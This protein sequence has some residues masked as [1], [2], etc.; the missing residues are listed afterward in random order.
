MNGHAAMNRIY[1]LVWSDRFMTWI[2]AAECTRGRGKRSSVVGAGLMAALLAAGVGVGAGARAAPAS[3]QLPTGGKVV[4]GQAQLQQSGRTLDINQASQRAVIDWASFNVGSA[5]Q[6]NFKQ[7]SA[8]SA[9]LNRVLD[10]QP[11]EILGRITANGQVFLVNPG[12]VYFGRTASV[13]VGGLVATTHDMANEDFMAGR[14]QFKRGNASG[15]VVN[16]GELRAALGG[17]IALLAPE[18]RNSGLIVAQLGTVALASGESVTLQFDGNNSLAG[19]VVEPSKIKAL[20]ENRGAVLAPGGIIILSAQALDRLQGGVVRNSGTLEATGMA[21]KGGKIVLEASDRIDNSGSISAHAG[22]DGSPAGQVTLSAPQVANLGSIAAAATAAAGGHIELAV[23]QFTQAVSGLLDAS[24]AEQG[25]EIVIQASGDVAIQGRVQAASSQGQG[26]HITVAAQSQLRLQDATVDASGASAGG[27]VRLQAEAAPQP[28]PL[29][30]TPVDPTQPVP[31]TSLLGNT[32]VSAG[33]RRGRGGEVTLT[34]EHVGLFDTSV[35]DVS[36]ASG[37]GRARVGGGFQGSDA[38]VANAQASY[39]APGARIAADATAQGDGGEV[40]VWADGLTRFEGG[41]SARGAADGGDGGQAEVSGKGQLDFRGSA[42]LRAPAG[43]AGTL[44][45]DP[46]NLTIS[47]GADTAVSGATPFDATGTGSVLSVNTL[48]NALGSGNVTVSTGAGGGEAGTITVSN[49][50][51]WFSDFS[52]TMNAASTISVNANLIAAGNGNINLNS[53]SGGLVNA[54]SI[55]TA[56]GDLTVNVATTVSGAGF[57]NVLGAASFTAGDTISLA[58]VGNRF[59]GAVS[60]LSATGGASQALLVNSQATALKGATAGS[61]GVSI[62]STG[63]ITTA[64]SPSGINTTGPLALST[65]AGSNG[66]ITYTGTVAAG[67]NLSVAADG[68][69][70]IALADINGAATLTSVVAGGAV[71]LGDV[72]TG[73]LTLDAASGNVISGTPGAGGQASGIV[74][75]TGSSITLNDPIRTKGGNLVFNATGGDFTAITGADITTTADANTATTSGSVTVTASG[76]VTLKNITTSGA[77]NNIGVGSNGAAVIVSSTSGT[78]N[79]GAITTSGG[80]ATTGAQ[81]NRNGGN[82]GS[83]V[84]GAGAVVD[85]TTQARGGSINLNG[86]L[87]AI[88]GSP[89][90]A[91]TQGLGGYIEVQSPAVLTANR[92]VSSGATSGNI[93]F[94]SNIDSDVTPRSLTVTGGIGDVLMDG[95]VGGSAPLSSL[96]VTGYRIDLEK[97]ITTNAAGGVVATA[98]S[99][100]H[101]GDDDKTNGLG[102]LTINTNAGNGVVTLNSVNTYL[103]DAVTITRGSGAVTFSQWLYSKSGERNNLTFNGA[104]G[105][106]ISVGRWAGGTAMSATTALGDVLVSTGTDLTFSEYVSAKSLVALNSTGRIYLG[107]DTYASYFDGASGVQLKTTGTANAIASDENIHLGSNITLSHASAPLNVAA[108]NGAIDTYHFADFTTAGGDLTLAAGTV[109]TSGTRTLTLGGDT[110]LSTSGGLISLTGVGVSQTTSDITLNAGSGKIRIDGGGGAVDVRSRLITTNADTGGT[111]A[112]LITNVGSANSATVRSVTAQTGSFQSGLIAS[113][114]TLAATQSASGAGNLNLMAPTLRFTAAKQVRITSAGDDSGRSFTVTGTDNSGNPLSENIAGGNAA[115]VTTTASF[116]T[117]TSIAINGASAGTVSAGLVSNDAIAGSLNQ[118]AGGGGWAATDKIDIKTLS[119]A[120]AGAISITASA[121][122]IDELGNFSVGS[123]LDVR[124]SGRSTGMALTGDVSATTVTIK[125]GVGPLALGTRSITSTSGS[126]YLQGLGLTQSAGSTVNSATTISIYGSDYSSGTL[127]SMTLAGNLVAANTGASAI[128][129]DDTNALQLGNVTAGTL[130]TRGGLVLGTNANMFNNAG[131]YLGRTG[132]IRGALTQAAGTTLKIGTLQ[133]YQTGGNYTLAN[134]GNEIVTLGRIDRGGALTIVDTDAEANGLNS[135]SNI[136]G[137]TTGNLISITTAGLLNMS[138]GTVLGQG[139][140]LNSGAAGITSSADIQGHSGVAANVVLDAGSGNVTLNNRLYNNGAG[141]DIV[142]QNANNVQLNQIELYGG[143]LVLGT[144]GTPLTGNVTATHRMFSGSDVISLTGVV[145]GSANFYTFNQIYRVGD[146]TSGGLFSLVNQD[147]LL[148]LQGAI[149]AA[150]GNVTV[151]NTNNSTTIAATG[152]V[153]ATAGNVTIAAR[154]HLTVT[155]GGTVTANTATKNVNLQGATGNWG[156]TTSIQGAISAGS[157]GIVVS[158]PY[159]YVTTGASGTLTTTGTATI[160]SAPNYA[161]GG[162]NYT[163]VINAAVAADAGITIN[164]AGTFASN[165]AGTLTSSAG[166]IAIKTFWDGSN[167]RAL[168]LGGNVSASA[169]GV[170]LTSA[171][172]ITQSAGVITT[173][174]TVSGPNQ[175]GGASLT[176]STPSARGAVSLALANQIGGLGPFYVYDTGAGAITVTDTTGGLLLAGAIE[177]SHGAV[178]LSTIGGALN[179]GT[180]N[181][182]AGGQAT[183]GAAI[184][185]TGRG[186]IQSQGSINSTGGTAGVPRTGANGGGTITLTGHDGTA[187]GAISLAGTLETAN[188][189]TSA[190]KIRGTSDLILPNV[191]AVNGSLVLGDDTATVG[192]ITGNVTQAVLTDLDV[193]TLNLGTATNAIG[194]SVVVANSGNTIT[195]LGLLNVGNVGGTQYDLDVYD[196]TSGLNLTAAVTSAGGARIRTAKGAGVVGGLGIGTQ[197]VSARGDVF[198]GGEGVTQGATSTINADAAAGG[199]V[200]GAIRVDGGGGTNAIDL[201]GTVITDNAGSNAIQIVNAKD[202]TLN[203]ISAVAGTVALGIPADTD[204]PTPSAAL[205]LSGAVTQTTPGTS[206][207][208]AQTLAI[209]AG[210]VTLSKTAIDNLGT[211][212]TTGAL[213]LTDVAGAGTAG[214]KLTGNATLGAASSIETTN[215]PL[216]LDTYTV[217]ATGFDMVLKGVGVSQTTGSA[218]KSTTAEIFGSTGSVD[219]FSPLNN[220]T[221]QV[222]VTATGAAVNLQD[223]NQLSMNT[224]TGKLATTT[225]FK[226]WAGTQVVMTPE[227]ITT[228]TGAIE[229]KSLGGNLAT[230]GKLTT[231]SGHVTLGATGTVTLS[232]A[233][234]S[235]SGNIAVEGAVIAS[236]SGAG[237]YIKTLGAG[238]ID[239]TATTGNFTQGLDVPYQSGSGDITINAPAGNANLANVTSASGVLEVN[240]GG[241]V[242]QQINTAVTVGAI[243]V[244]TQKA[245]GG[246]IDLSASGND[247]GAVRLRSLSADGSAAAGGAITYLD[248]TGFGVREILTTGNVSLTG[249]A[250]ITTDAA[251]FPGTIQAAALT[252]KTLNDAGAN[253]T[254][255]AAANDIATLTAQVLRADGVTIAGNTTNDTTTGAAGTV[256]VTDANGFVVAGVS[257]GASTVLTGGA[258][259]EVTQTGA[260]VSA[261]LGLDGNAAFTLNNASLGVPL[262]QFATFASS[263]TGAVNVSTQL[264]LTIG[265]VNPTGVTTGGAAL[266][267][268]AP[269]ISITEAIDTRSANPATAGGAVTLSTTGTTTAGNLATS[270]NGSIITSGAAAA[271][272][273]GL[274]GGAAGNVTLTAAG[275]SLTV[276]AAI[277]ALGGAGDGAG[278]AGTGGTVKLL[279]AA[280]AVSQGAGVAG[281]AAGKLEV[282]AQGASS[283][284]STSN[285]AAQLAA[286]ITGTGQDFGYRSGSSFAVGGGD[287]AIPGITTQGGKIDLDAGAVAISLTEPVSTRGGVFSAAGVAGFDSSGVLL[288]TA[289]DITYA[290]GVYKDGGTVTITSAAGAVSTGTV[291]TDGSAGAGAANAGAVTLTATAG[292]LTVGQTNA[293]GVGTGT[294][295]NVGLS[296]GTA[297]RIAGGI[298]TSGGGGAAAGGAIS[299]TGPAIVQGGDRS[300]STGSGAGNI[301]FSGT[302]NSDGTARDLTLTAGTGNITLGG[303]VGGSSPLDVINIVSATDVG[304]AAVTATTLTQQAGS[305]TTT[306]AGAVALSGNLGFIGNQLTVNAAVTAAGT[307]TISNSG[308]FTTAAAGDIA[309]A[310]GFTQNGT[311][312]SQLAGDISSTNTGIAFATPVTLKGAVSMNTDT[313]AGNIV[314]AS[315]VDSDGTPRDLT[316]SAGTGAVTLADAAGGNSALGALVANAA[317]TTTFTGSVNAAS[318]T[319]DAA[320]TTAINGGAVTTSGSQTYNDA[321]T[322][323]DNTVLTGSSVTTNGTITGAAHSLQVAGNAV[324]GDAAADT[325]TGLTT[326]EVTGTTRINTD[327]V[328]SADAQ[329]YTGA[330]TLGTSSTLTATNDPIVFAST[331]DS[332]ASQA[333]ALT[334]GAGSG[335][336]SFGGAVGGAVNGA[337]GALAVNSSGTTTFSGAVTAASVTTNVGGTVAL[338]GGSVTTSGAQSYG[339]N[340][341]LG[342]DTALSGSSVAFAGTLEGAGT[343]TESLAI[344]GDASFASTVGAAQALQSLSVSGTTSLGGNVSTSEAGGGSGNQSYGG[345]VTL[346]APAALA[347]GSGAVAVNG[348]LVG[349]NNALAISAGSVALGD[350]SGADTVGGLASLAI[351]GPTTIK[352]GSV[353]TSGAQSYDG[354]VRIGHNDVPSTGSTLAATMVSFKGAVDSVATEANTLAITGNAAFGDGTGSD[355]VGQSNAGGSGKLGSLAVSGSTALAANANAV[356]TTGGQSYGGALTLADAS[357][358]AYTLASSGNGAIAFGSSVDG[359]SAGGNASLAVNTGG[360]SSFGGTVGNTHSLAALATDAGGSTAL[361]GG[362]VTTSGTQAYGDAVVLGADTTLAGVG[363]TLASTV[364]SDGTPRSLLVNDSGTTTLGG[365]VGGDGSV[366]GERL[367]SLT[368]DAAGSLALDASSVR[369]SGAQQYGENATL[370]ADTT[371]TGA[372]VAFSGT[373]GGAQALTVNASGATTFG[374]LVGAGTALASLSTDG[375]GSTAINGGGVATSGAQSYGD[376]VT[377]GADTTLMGASVAFAKKVDGAHALTVN[378]SGAT[379]FGGAVGSV[380]AL[381]TLATDGAGS[382]ALNGGGVATSGAQSYGDD[383]TLGAGTTLGGTDIAFA[384]KID[385]AQ[386]LAVNASGATRFGGAIGSGTALTS[387]ATDAA[388]STAIDGGSVATNGAQS[389]GDAVTLGADTTLSAGSVSTLGTVD[390]A[391][392]N[393]AIVGNAVLGDAAADRISGLGTLSVSGTTLITADTVSGSGTQTYTGALTLG[394]NTSL[395]STA[396]ALVFGSTV[397]SAGATPRSLYLASAAVGGQSFTAAVGGTNALDVLRIESAG[398]V[399]QGGSAPIRAAKLAIK[400]AGNATLEHA[401][402]DVDVLAALLSGNASLSFVDADGLTIGTI[403]SA[404]LQIVGI[405][406]GAGTSSVTLR[407]GGL[408]SQE[409]AAPIALDGNLTLDTT[410]YDADDVSIKNTAAGG[411]SLDNSLIAGD[412]SLVSSGNVSQ[413]A[414]VNAGPSDAWLQVGGNFNT[415]GGGSFAPGNS[416]ENLF[417]GGGGAAAPNQIRLFGVITLSMAGTDLHA[418]A[419]NGT[420]TTTAD[421]AAAQFGGGVSVISDAGGKNISVVGNGAAV[422]LGENNSVGGHLKI[423]TAGTYSNLG[424][425]VATGIVQSGALSLGAAS[426]LVQQSTANAGSVIAGTGTLALSDAANSFTGAVSLTALGMDATLASATDV[427]FGAANVGSLSVSAA[428]KDLSQATGTTLRTPTLAIAA[429]RHVALTNAN[430]VGTLSASSSGSF[431]FRNDQNLTIGAGGLTT[432]NQAITLGVKGDLA[433]NAT[434][435]SGSAATTVIAHDGTALFLGTAAGGGLQLDNTELA[436]IHAGST[437]LQSTTG[438]GSQVT[439]TAASFAATGGAVQLTAD[440][441]SLGGSTTGNGNT[442]RISGPV[443][444][445]ADTL[446]TAP[447]TTFDHAVQGTTAGAESLA[448]VGDAVFAANVGDTVALKSLTVSGASQLAGPVGTSDAGGGSGNQSYGGAV[449]LTAPT[450][451]AAT[452]GTV[453]LSGGLV[454]GG[455]TLA[456][457][458]GNVALGDGIGAD[459]IA[460]LASLDITGATTVKASSVASSGAQTYDGDV[461]IGRNDVPATGTALTASTVRFKGAVD[462]VATESNSLAII[463]NAAFGDGVGNDDVG[464]AQALA[465]LGV[466]GSTGLAASTGRISSTGAQTYAGSLTLADGASVTLAASSIDTAAIA[467]TAGGTTSGIAFDASGAVTVAGSVGTDIGTVTVTQSDGASFQGA[468]SAAS[469]A[470]ADSHAGKTVAFQGDLTLTSGLSAAAGTAAYNVAITGASN[471]IAGATTLAHSGN[472]SLGD[473]AGDATTFAGGLSHV[474]GPSAITGTVNATAGNLGLGA[475]TLA[476]TLNATAGGVSTGSLAANGNADAINGGTVSIGDITLADGNSLALAGSSIDTGAIS[477]TAAGTASHVAF[478]ATGAVTVGGAIATDIASVTVTR[479]AGAQFVGAVSATTVDIADSTGTVQFDAALTATTLATAN[480]GYGLALLGGASIANAT[481]LANTGTLTLGDGAGD[482]TT[483]AGGLT[484]TAAGVLQLAGTV[485][486]TNAAIV[487]GSARP[488]TLTA[489][490]TLASGSADLSLDGNVNGA[491]ALTLNSSGITRLGGAFGGSTALTA[492]A[493]DAAGSTAITGGALTLSGALNLG[494]AASI[495]APTTVTAGTI[496]TGSTLA[497]GAH[498]LALRTDA[499]ALGGAVSGSGALSIAPKTAAT[500]I[501]IA[502]GNGALNLDAGEWAQ[503]Q[504]GFVQVTVGAANAGAIEVGA[505]AATVALPDSTL[506]RSG[507]G[508]SAPAGIAIDGGYLRVDAATASSLGGVVSGTGQLETVGSGALALQA[509]APNT[510]TGNTLIGSGATLRAVSDGALASTAAVRNSGL[511]DVS[512]SNGATTATVTGSGSVDLG[513]QRLTLTAADGSITG[514]ISGSGGALTLQGGALTLAGSNS[515][516]GS[517][518]IEGGS[519]TASHSQALGTAAG[520]TA[521]SAGAAL[522]LDGSGGALALAEPLS[523]AGTGPAG[524]GALRNLAGN[525]SVSGA[526][527]L[528]AGN[529]TIAATAGNLALGGAIDGGADL[530]IQSAGTVS[531]GA[532]VGGTT[533][534]ASLSTDASGSTALNGGSV[535]TTGTQS[536]GDAL[537]LGA[538]TTL[539]GSTVTNAAALA[540]AGHALTVTGDAVVGGAISGVSNL[541]VSGSTAVGADVGTTGTQ[542]YTGAV[543]LTQNATLASSGAG[544]AANI[545]FAA[546]VDGAKTL[547][548]NSAGTVSFGAAV[549]GTTALTSLATDAAGSTAVNGGSVRTT[550]TQSYGDALT[551]GAD[552]TL[553][554]STVTNAAVLTGA[555]HALTVTGNAVVGGAI[556]GVSNLAVSGSTAMGADIGTTGTQAYSGAVSLTQNATLASSGAGAAG[557]IAFA[558]TVDGAK[559]L[560]LNSAG[561]VSFGAA[562]GGT[563]ALTSLATDATGSTAVNGGSVR[564]TGTQ[565]YGDVIA[566]GADTTLQGSTVTNA[567][568]LTGAGHA[569]TVTGDAVVGGAISGVSNLAVSGS[570]AVGADV[571]TT[572]T[573]AYTG[574]VS[575]TQ[576]AT[577]ASSG[578]GAAGDIAFASTVDGAKT[579][580][581]NS[582]G[583]VSFGAA[584]GG[585]TALTSL[586]TDAG[587]ST[588]INGGSVRTSGTQSYGDAVALG[589]DTTL[590]GSTV[591]NAAAIAGNAH[592]LT[593]TGNAVVD[594]AISGVTSYAVSGS[595]DLGADVT[596][597][598]SQTYSGAV[599]LSGGDRTLS[600]STVSTASTLAG[601]GHALSVSGNAVVGGAVSGVSNLAVSGTSALGADVSTTGTQAYTGAVSLTQNATLASSGA[602]A[603]GDIAFAS[604][605]DGAQTLAVNSAGTLS[606]GA[607]VG[608]T[609]ALTSLATD[610]SGSTA[611]NGGSVRTSGTQSYGDAVALGADTTLQGSTVTNAAAIAGN[612]HALTVTG[613]AVV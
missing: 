368:T 149:T 38:D 588:A 553:Q 510:Y 80:T 60:L 252:A 297:V 229:L 211:T 524:S 171:G 94:L 315:T 135:S 148:T 362:S 584:V 328:T 117:I 253:I 311:G 174:G 127:G 363:V 189:S 118:N 436:R 204:L 456:I 319:T 487:F 129:I 549:G 279:A 21:M 361:N 397:D 437:T 418:V 151:T 276:A 323:G 108:P 603:A 48:Q 3:D 546:T 579:L 58:N 522:V 416:T 273:S 20:V 452:S 79:L 387:L 511:L 15:S 391:T 231:G 196:S 98:V 263:A 523:L 540:G 46:Y 458:A 14:T 520:G 544:A 571:G 528:A 26:G 264:P 140:Q 425:P 407:V 491:H 484:A 340:A 74:T 54:T 158:S 556:S 221:G 525:N 294:G 142:I 250:A 42:D 230:P 567:A 518:A 310:G 365:A 136:N 477:G 470:I 506:L 41:I 569:L 444:L 16:E 27:S 126:I 433:L 52:L 346:T 233:I 260:I 562:V 228:T 575:L 581:V 324:F 1:R 182:Y 212:A 144:V 499:I 63:N 463:G 318:V 405:S 222:T 354:D 145:N 110:A 402:N 265:Q 49:A 291:T 195:Q 280:G 331:V 40:V 139:V 441:V 548:V 583:T 543:N 393:L 350:G 183:G 591:T 150:T 198:L 251:G 602:G 383:V 162:T 121:N 492:L 128:T 103:D 438:A 341:T 268:S 496:T 320:G 275:D 71:T 555:G 238:T 501:G 479:S 374:G 373:L 366:P 355:G 473:A 412:F 209:K 554:G 257:T 565:S 168:T 601:A 573:Q 552:T 290:A 281:I 467:G 31:T 234:D 272:G 163:T 153:T 10:G 468:V 50:V 225:S 488:I 384:K 96:T 472:L 124:A 152:A 115:S 536:Y 396:G 305:G 527:T 398:V 306:L 493:T 389:Y 85:A 269:S 372:S 219:L 455:Q 529:V 232:N 461:R 481:T 521:V 508:V 175:S 489:D 243:D 69:G 301:G 53:T 9:T 81:A 517:T 266:T 109:A 539:Q 530:S 114:T 30:G 285:A 611:I 192:L 44:L 36:G 70:A 577:L 547:A 165:A 568:A 215:G 172:A 216:N 605:V 409:A 382:T 185:L 330:V 462:S 111:P 259:A 534:L 495:S 107:G 104:G 120:T 448:L 460:G 533:A 612:A 35:V 336:V 147:R 227:D 415:T 570:T 102:A 93:T 119:A 22:A 417:G 475:T 286:K 516:T 504:D 65:A 133:G 293:R 427:Q 132:Y 179:L 12:G 434:V 585:T 295:A 154:D 166:A 11:S 202:V 77:D 303:A 485:Q 214:L 535:R 388:G 159:G 369:T 451:L 203:T 399:T 97:N 498:D 177:S 349:G 400:A 531:F 593:V 141:K 325:V 186:I 541:A 401:A 606:F 302:L 176:D 67:G 299:V 78:L 282:L 559:T 167:T 51:G 352:A 364:K 6:V 395:T 326:L 289:G 29:P 143:K 134:A 435:D 220:F 23:Q 18:V 313:G 469:V 587:G 515:Y 586:A 193:K 423:T 254:L 550:G 454:G 55:R 380:T 199:A 457:T 582:A 332:A 292:T 410:A 245:G 419:D 207:L 224:L 155:N 57:Y 194:G 25:G 476:G 490:T 348:G 607:A 414:G 558:S 356:S 598:A 191:N 39:V 486:T 45:L 513:A 351:T 375:A 95:V 262:N 592:A 599:T 300:L 246:Y 312:A 105:G 170:A 309:A 100:L 223:A 420:T 560:A 61:G 180:S 106:A 566:L 161:S 190:I 450:A 431:A 600:G 505:A 88:G 241:F 157:G 557:D 394:G 594:A 317:G 595:A 169:N 337:L 236:R 381:T 359:A 160:T 130:A 378:A 360:S 482:T 613:N 338:D 164:S 377:L 200:G 385:G 86:D 597:S 258:G 358:T 545:A 256:R 112:V 37:G 474:S 91:A 17:Y 526:I 68:T 322:L 156:Y 445:A 610:A 56:G 411:T 335:A 247:A 429:A 347:A 440:A 430:L 589:A 497:A 87:N 59:G 446:I 255:T 509:G 424:S 240:A 507:A 342:A 75:I 386:T 270:G 563:T 578:A 439:A 66:S 239:I 181:V 376:D 367:S 304:A 73:A 2:A 422:T 244:T 116:R 188:A 178:T 334:V 101:L 123:S 298:D 274:A 542:A 333:H 7:P 608:G 84:L 519:L 471:S 538:D 34:G 249:K 277:T 99:D 287:A 478:D 64:A 237:D 357:A 321:V 379:T 83:I 443:T 217:D 218:I 345:A 296:G 512:A 76:N 392:H 8:Q 32:L 24:G 113:A 572:G 329:T 561:T 131:S 201:S 288:S 353:T 5:G 537:T 307:A 208:S 242:Q 13:E 284:L 466:S 502:G 92:V 261:K 404:A 33:S 564:T 206:T 90:G 390:A 590:Q 43:H 82:A 316:L 339:E 47:T 459:A 146:F 267:I 370:G 138:G 453:A 532:A 371:L 442:L 327:T 213:T 609:T 283:L 308:L 421:I 483:F 137:G 62:T 480:K 413:R 426:F 4:A 576:N 408:L 432:T 514:S 447:T 551:L 89:F 503:L 428:G 122:V 187:A 226:A 72:N 210:V 464:Q 344:T 125:T 494:D 574:A 28:Q 314:F 271:G 278:A 197:N 596:S 604:T 205:P 173:T 235:A 403:E 465:S 580:A 184:S 406:D 248:N 500:T 449:T 343:A 19:L